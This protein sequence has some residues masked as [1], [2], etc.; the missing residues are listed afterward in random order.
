[1]CRRIWSRETGS[2]VPSR[3]SLLIFHTPEAEYGAYSRGCSRFPRRRPFNNLNRHTPLGQ[4]RIYRVTQ[5]HTNGVHCRESAGTGPL[6]SPQG[7][8]SNGCCHFAGHHG[9]INMRL[10]FPTPTIGMK[11]ACGKYRTAVLG[12]SCIC[13]PCTVCVDYVCIASHHIL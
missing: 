12:F 11:W 2:A 3:T 4:C 9:P 13:F 6:V 1:M 7:S 8:S 5:M 10:S